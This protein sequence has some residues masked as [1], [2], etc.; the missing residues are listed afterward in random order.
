[1]GLKGISAMGGNAR[2]KTVAVLGLA[3]KPNTA[4]IREAPSI[5]IVQTLQDAGAR[6]RAYDPVGMDQARRV[7]KNVDY[8]ESAYGAIEGADAVVIVTEWDA[9][10]ALD[11][12]R[13]KSLLNS[14]RSEERRVGKEGVSTCRSRWSPYH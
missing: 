7:I 10:R 9:F 2:G 5:A 11:L 3:F 13:V 6:V 4:D 14:P 8:A 1:M 12:K